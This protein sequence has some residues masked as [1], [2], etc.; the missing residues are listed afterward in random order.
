MAKLN[1]R[2]CNHASRSSQVDGN[3]KT[4][5]SR[6]MSDFLTPGHFPDVAI[7]ALQCALP[8]LAAP[9]NATRL[10]YDII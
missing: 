10:K 1:L 3:P 6:S 5:D 8:E 9:S 2:E 7:A 4:D